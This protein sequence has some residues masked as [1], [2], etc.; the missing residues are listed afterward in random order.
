M[1]DLGTLLDVVVH[2]R[3][4]RLD[5]SQTILPDPEKLDLIYLCAEAG[6]IPL[7]RCALGEDRDD[8]LQQSGYLRS[9]KDPRRAHGHRHPLPQKA[10]NQAHAPSEAKR[11]YARTEDEDHPPLSPPPSCSGSSWSQL[12]L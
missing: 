2:S 1:K 10:S 3:F 8:P 6:R 7:R 4:W 5:A 9:T 12:R 11:L